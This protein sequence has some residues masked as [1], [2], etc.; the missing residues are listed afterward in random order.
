MKFQ[1]TNKTL[2][3]KFDFGKSEYGVSES[4]LDDMMYRNWYITYCIRHVLRHSTCR[5]FV[6]CGSANGLSAFFALSEITENY[7]FHLYD[8]W[9]MMRE[10]YLQEGE[11]HFA[12]N[13]ATLDINIVKKNLSGF[14]VIYHQG[15][16]PETLDHAAPE[17]ISYLHVD[18]N[19]V[20]TTAEILD[21]FYPR[22]AE[23]GIIL[24]DD[25]GWLAHNRT[26]KLVDSYCGNIL[27]LPT[28]QGI[29][30]K[31]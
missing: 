4:N 6:E 10:D 2:K 11:K 22:L 19:S 3:E 23:R 21:F 28:G 25:Y 17:K 1:R 5:N 13:Y 15:Y 18:V 26:R 29:F 14:N 8:S 30:F 12:G 31:L 16:I 9:D 7:S 20:Q 24:F 27:C